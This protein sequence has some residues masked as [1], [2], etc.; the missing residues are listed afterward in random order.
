MGASHTR[1]LLIVAV[2]MGAIAVPVAFS[3]TSASASNARVRVGGTPIEPLQSF[4]VR[5][6]PAAKHL[7]VTV[8]LQPRD[9][10]GL[11]N[12]ATAV[13]TP[14][15]PEYGHFLTV[16]QFAA[17]FGAV[18][19]HVAA[20]T[21]V[22]RA[23]GVQVSAPTRNSLQLQVSGTVGQLNQAFAVTEQQVR[24]PSGRFAYAN[25]VAPTLPA[26][27]SSYVQ[28]VIGLDNVNPDQP[29]GL[30]YPTRSRAG[31]HTLR[32]AAR[33]RPEYPTNGGPQPGC[34]GA[35]DL[36]SGGAAGEHGLTADEV[37][38]AYNFSGL[39]AQ[40]DLGQ[41]QNIAM[42]E[43]Q[44]FNPTD[45][46]TYQACYGTSASVTTINVAGGPAPDPTD[47]ESALDI[48]QAIGLAPKANILVYQGSDTQPAAILG[49]I[50][51]A[52]QAKVISSSYGACERITGAAT[53]NAESTLLQEAATQGQSFFISSGDAGSAM[54]FQ[55]TSTMANP[56]TSLSVIDPGS[57]PFATG[58]GGTFLYT[59]PA[60]PSYYAPGDPLVEGV[61]N[62]GATQQNDGSYRASGTGGG[63][64]SFFTMPAYQSGAPATL[65]VVNP[66]SSVT[67]C[68]ATINCREVPDVSAD[69]D[70]NTG[71]AVYSTGSGGAAWGVTGGTSA[72]A[73]LW[74]AFTALANASAACRGLSIGFANPSLYAIAGSS[75]NSNFNDVTHPNPLYH[76]P[77][78]ANAN[79][80]DS[81]GVNGDKYQ[82]RQG[83]DLATGLG[84]MNAP[85]LAASLCA[86]RAPVYTVSVTSPG[87]QSSF[88]GT[89]ISL[90]VTGADSGGV[91]LGYAASGLPAG[92]TMATNG[93]I[94]GTPTTAQAA[95]VT[96]YAADA[97]TNAGSTTFTWSIVNRPPPIIRHRPTTKSVTLTGLGRRKPKLT[98]T[99]SAGKNAP[100]LM[101]VAILLPGGLKFAAKTK[102]LDKGISLKSGRKKLKFSIK[103]KRGAL[104]ITFKSAT[105][106]ATLTLAKPAVTITASEAAKIRRHKVKRLAIVLRTTDTSHQ[107]IKLT[108]RLKKLS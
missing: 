1:L 46:A 69:A 11:K 95:T 106:R 86:A 22:L 70:P 105:R 61:W 8:A 98:L 33:R 37:A 58:V 26:N 4:V 97:Y 94:S 10:V 36:Q 13:A 73:P 39:Y 2:V 92:L 24:L 96:V 100:A 90:A 34:Q 72:S 82:V 20:V 56:D 99:L 52:N 41:G 53:I 88:V 80:N 50:V 43:E 81:I 6:S 32:L 76:G 35:K 40:G 101:S 45:I 9:P 21:K 104:M 16:P 55:A 27:I 62:E 79:S 107:T 23:E 108:L 68:G 38:T 5:N 15:T 83:Y 19:A 93:V 25:N 49:A 7:M 89:P 14:G 64:S 75:Y 51:S 17:R 31:R 42:F 91:A 63:I 18:P 47:G 102:T 54:C 29:A 57:Q 30:A 84:S 74:A 28:G 66:D 60:S 103:V 59:N 78:A 87:T 71:Y 85:T 77:T 3:V 67:P 12:F 65:G 44:P 48:E